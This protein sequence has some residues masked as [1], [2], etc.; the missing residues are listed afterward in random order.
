[1]KTCVLTNHVK[2]RWIQAQVEGISTLAP[3]TAQRA[4]LVYND[5]GD[6]LVG[7]CSMTFQE[8]FDKAFVDGNGDRKSVV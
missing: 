5:I 4:T 3:F 2:F 6:G 7:R 8:S 1:M